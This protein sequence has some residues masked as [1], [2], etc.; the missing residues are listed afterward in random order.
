MSI[1]TESFYITGGTLHRNAACYI[2]RQAD[3]KLY[4]GLK[5]NR[6]CYVLTSRQ[7]GKSSLMVRTANRLREEGVGVAVLDLTAIGQNLS[8]EQWY[9]GLRCQ[10]GQRLD[11]EDELEEF[12]YENKDVGPLQRWM[13]MLKE[14]VL[15]HYRSRIVIFVDEID[16]VRSLPFSTDEFF[17]GIRELYN[18]RSEDAGLE[19]LTFCLLGVATPS[20]LIRDTRITP[21]NIGERVE[22]NDFTEA[23]ASRLSEGLQ[24]EEEQARELL[25]RILYWTIGHP[26]LT[27]RLCRAVAEDRRVSNEEG[28]DA[29]CE[30]LFLSHRAQ[31]NDDNLLFVRERML[32]SE[33]DIAGLLGLYSRVRRGKRVRDE[34]T[35]VLVSILKLSGIVRAES[36]N[37]RVRNRI[38]RRVFNEQWVKENMPDAELRRQRAAFWRGLLAATVIAGVILALIAILAFNLKRQRDFAKKQELEKSRLLYASHMNL[39]QQAWEKTDIARVMELLEGQLPKPGQADLRSFEWYYLWQLCH[40]ELFTLQ[41]T[42]PVQSIAFSPDGK[43]LAVGT[44]T[45]SKLQ[46]QF[47]ANTGMVKLWDINTRQEMATFEGHMSNVFSIAFSPDGKTL[48]T[49]SSDRTVKLWDIPTGQEL[50]T[51]TGHAGAVFFVSFSPD[52]KTLATG[53]WDNTVKLWDVAKRQEVGTLE[54]HTGRVFSVSFSPDGKTLATSSDDTTIKLWDV[55]RKREVATLMGHTR[56]VSSVS[57]SPDGKTLATGSWDKTVKLWDVARQREVATFKGNASLVAFSPDGKTLVTGFLGSSVKLLDVAGQR[58]VA[59]F[60]GHMEPIVSVT[61]SPDSKLLATG[62]SDKTVKIWNIALEQEWTTLKGSVDNI[63]SML[64]G[65]TGDITSISF[66]PDGKTLATGSWNSTLLK[67]W[68]VTK[69]RELIALKGHTSNVLSIAFSPDGKT[70]ASG[71]EDKTIKLWNV[72]RGEEII[73]LN[74]HTDTVW[75][76]AFSPDGKTLAT[77]GWDSTVKLWAIATGRELITLNGHTDKVWSVAFS[78]DGKILATGG[79]DKMVRLWNTTT[80]Q[81]IIVLNGYKA[82]VV[83]MV[84][85]PD[86]KILVAASDDNIVKIWDVTSRQELITLKGYKTSV[87]SITFSPDGKRLITGSYDGTVRLWDTATWQEVINLKVQRSFNSMT[88]SPDGKIL[89]IGCSDGIARLLR[90]ATKEE[91]LARNNQ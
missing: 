25:K 89:A 64:K 8:V 9:N 58:E 3:S 73:T 18:D 81:E 49:G 51:L 67:L 68:D 15:T 29:K 86:S 47:F 42:D 23:E 14:V 56:P 39:A 71:S 31:E 5:E 28:V 43:I 48:A 12:W 2:E 83:S 87:V 13:R 27:Q 40:S 26:Y 6:F 32:R 79:G 84:F 74:G 20:D 54:E 1:T 19:R 24:R 38:Y 77:G 62:S 52:G 7:M 50:A 69:N 30:E 90:A 36:G 82:P 10:M 75:S 55:D 65:R 37:L 45:E 4:N 53:S 80:W 60:K 44:G 78:P 11:L 70:L 46:P 72:D 17:A 61:F 16:T 41:H 91:V 57:F 22:L 66:S 63:T 76:I 33:V 59:T 85:S 21:F 35:N 88:L 34:E